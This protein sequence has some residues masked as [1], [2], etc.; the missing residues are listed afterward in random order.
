MA[1]RLRVGEK[2]GIG[3]GVV[4]LVFL[5]VVWHD[6]LALRALIEDYRYLSGV[7]G[8][9]QTQSFVIESRLAAMREA[10]ER[11][12][13]SRDSLL[14]DRVRAEG[15]ELGAALAELGGIDTVSVRTVDLLSGLT[16]DFLDRFSRIEAAWRLKGF[17]ENSGLQGA[18]RDTAHELEQRA[19]RELPQ[20]QSQVLQLRRREKDY[21]LRGDDEY[22]RMVEGIAAALIISIDA[23]PLAPEA[24]ARL[25]DL[26]RDYGRNFAALV[27]QDRLIAGLTEE[28]DRAADRIGPLVE[29]NLA[30][31]EAFMDR[32]SARFDALSA[33]RARLALSVAVG[34]TLFGLVFAVLVTGRIVRP[35]RRMAEL[36]D[37]MTHEN[38]AERVQAPADPRDEIMAM[39]VSLNT[40]ADH[41]ATFH[42][43]WRDS[44]RE[45]IALRDAH[46][47]GSRIEREEALTELRAALGGKIHTLESLRSV[48]QRECDRMLEAAERLGRDRP[49]SS[50]DVLTLRRAAGT[51][52]ELL[53]V[54]K[55]G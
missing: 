32:S 20:L 30:E 53:E 19:V 47:A 18:F 46:L 38:P 25:A 52:R 49:Q 17:D 29:R 27:E 41:K 16:R 21:L 2:I 11:F 6:Q 48:L 31:A 14:P 36:L 8:A 4:A 54:L 15:A 26:V 5:G 45:A 43:W 33:E 40:L 28:M 42:H 51:L 55:S 3:F 44:M 35:V 37:R 34:A 9:R 24:R 10:A 12:L 7:V 13:V 50:E 1:S 22:V 39:A 23:S